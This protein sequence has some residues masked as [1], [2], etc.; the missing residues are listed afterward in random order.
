LIST[1]GLLVKLSHRTLSRSA[2]ERTAVVA[3][4]AI[5][6]SGCSVLEEDKIDYKS[7]AKAPTLEI[8]PDLSQLR[9]DSRYALESNSATASGFQSAGTRVTDAG[10]AA[11]TMGD[12][13]MERQGNQ[14]WLV[15]A[16]PADKVWEPLREFWTSNGFTLIADS[17]DVGIME[18]DW[19]ENRAK[20]P[21]D[22]I[23]RTLGKVLDSLYSSGE[24][25]KFRTRVER[26]AQGGVDIYITHRGMAENYTSALKEQTIWQP[27]ASDAELE[28]EFLRRLMV[29][30]GASSEAA[31][32]AA[33]SGAPAPTTQVTT[34]NGQATIQINDSL[35]R[36]WRRTGV[37]LD[38]TGFTVEDRD[39]SQGLFFVRYVTPGSASDKEPGFF[40]RMFSSK[41]D[42][43][44]LSRY[45]LALT[46][47]DGV[48]SV[49]VLNATGQAE[50]SGNA[51]RILKLLA[52]ELR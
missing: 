40:A 6:V 39:R 48:V 42:D 20:I 26:N 36:A 22:I 43:I 9:R 49:R 45:R 50:T 11:N 23:R 33:T 19:A 12:V 35:D 1:K 17:P 34:V 2:F 4:L 51:E 16:R 24:R 30:L 31:K 52:N 3:A 13:R 21:Q 27:R 8:P 10:T 18:T 29:K 47:K 37:A 38:R 28:I 44:A 7:A 5:L 46:E 14:R 15:V 25:D 32:T 41:K